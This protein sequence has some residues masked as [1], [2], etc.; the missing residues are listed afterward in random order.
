MGRVE[1]EAK[2]PY[3]KVTANKETSKTIRAWVREDKE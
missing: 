3:K 2:S 1:G